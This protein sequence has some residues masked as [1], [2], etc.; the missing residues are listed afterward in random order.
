[1]SQFFYTLALYL[2]GLLIRLASFWNPKAMQWVEGRKSIF[3]RI[4][5]ALSNN[6]APIAWFHCAS[7]GEFE[8]ARP[9]IEQFKTEFPT[10]KIILTFFSPSGYEVRKNYSGADYIF[11]LPLD[12]ASN[13]RKFISL[14]KPAIVF[15]TKYEFW[16]YYLRQLKELNIPVISFSAIFRNE[17]IFF[18]DYGGFFRKIL[19]SFNYI[20]V[21]NA[22]SMELLK[23]NGISQASVAGDT[24]FDRVQAIARQK[25][26]LPMVAAFKKGQKLL[27]IGSSWPQDMAILIPF[28]NNFKAPLKTIVAPHEIH[29]NEIHAFQQQLQQ[30]SVRLSKADVSTIAG[31]DVLIIDNIGMLSSLYQYGEFAYIGGAFGKG[32]HNIL[33]A[34]TFGMP[35]FFGPNYQK[36]QEARDLV[37]SEA[38]ISVSSTEEL[39]RQFS[40][41]YINEEAR[42]KKAIMARQYVIDNTGAT[43]K[44]I[45][46]SRELLSKTTFS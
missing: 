24:R 5:H 18:K 21:Q 45:Q 26:E 28:L 10:I 32:L 4:A 46:Y 2:Y 3:E 11:Y 30:K 33:E 40:T 13:A 27:V 12:T 22:A 14:T 8:Q 39:T 6:T 25:K 31:Y 38:A 17:Q 1:M 20:F 34:A 44:I 43:G 16:Y 29:E 41:L 9:V 7:L 37:A 19:H 36:F 35:I 42:Q 23:N 15:F